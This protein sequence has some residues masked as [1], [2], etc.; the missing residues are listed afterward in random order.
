MDGKNIADFIDPDIEAKLEALEREEEKLEAAGFY[1]SDDSMVCSCDVDMINHS[2]HQTDSDDEREREELRAANSA[3]ST[4]HVKKNMKN[5]PVMPRT[6]GLTT[7]SQM[8]Q[9]LTKAGIDPSRVLERAQV[10]AKARATERKRKREEE[11]NEMELDEQAEGGDDWMDVDDD[12]QPRKRQKTEG[13]TVAL[14][15]HGKRQPKSD[16]ATIGMRDASVCLRVGCARL[17]GL[18]SLTANLQS[19][20]AAQFGP[21][22]AQPA[23]E[24][25][26]VGSRDSGQNGELHSLSVHTTNLCTA[27]K[28]PIC[29]KEKDGEDESPMT[30]GQYRARLLHVFMTMRVNVPIAVQSASQRGSV[31]LMS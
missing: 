29:W 30:R 18:I 21:A 14:G 11:E 19:H 16:R 4:S 15:P 25:W 8:A 12:A 13:G 28:A 1:A 22:G 27:A 31:A 2:F 6:A 20:Q 5:R 23:G 9:T 17:R 3:K 26:R 10:L 7:V 24:S